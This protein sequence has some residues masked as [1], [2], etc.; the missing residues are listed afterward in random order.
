MEEAQQ[1]ILLL[2][3]A[4]GTPEMASALRLAKASRERARAV[5]LV[6][7]Q[8]AVLCTLAASELESAR[9]LR[10]LLR[11]GVRCAYLAEDLGM[12]GYRSG[13]V[14]PGCQEIDYASLVAL[15]LADCA[16]VAGAF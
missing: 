12:R 2:R 9:Y 11:N 13:D 16:R 7:V 14:T 1:Q 6:L 4:P 8:D 3:S 15:L 5:A 10:T